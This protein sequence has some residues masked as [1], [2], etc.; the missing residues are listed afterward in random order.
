[1]IKVVRLLAVF[2]LFFSCKESMESRDNTYQYYSIKATPNSEL[3]LR[4]SL[5]KTAALTT[6]TMK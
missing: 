1:M 2:S 5:V 3:V 6:M 4:P